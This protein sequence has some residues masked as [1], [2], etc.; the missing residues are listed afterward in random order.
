MEK[1]GLKEFV[2]LAALLQHLCENLYCL[3]VFLL[4][5]TFS[6]NCLCTGLPGF[7]ISSCSFSKM[8]KTPVLLTASN[9]EVNDIK[10]K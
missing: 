2:S 3:L 4:H 9:T 6:S 7:T 8:D 5:W 1:G 10:S